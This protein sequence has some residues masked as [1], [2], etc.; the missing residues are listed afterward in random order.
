M[1]A[2]T[3]VFQAILIMMQ[4]QKPSKNQCFSN[5]FLFKNIGF[6][7]LFEADSVYR[8]KCTFMGGA[9][10]LRICLPEKEHFYEGGLTSSKLRHFGFCVVIICQSVEAPPA[11]KVLNPRS[12]T[13]IQIPMKIRKRSPQSYQFRY[14]TP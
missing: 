13:C 7:K 11:I 12:R 4:M 1:N 3:L 14:L 9:Y 2:K 6:C 8:R 5:I 10:F